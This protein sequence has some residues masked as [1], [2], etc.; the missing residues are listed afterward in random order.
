MPRLWKAHIT[1]ENIIIAGKVRGD[2]VAKRCLFLCR[3]LFCRNIS[4]PKLNIVEGAV[5]HGQCQ[6]MEDMLNIDEV[7]KYLEIDMPAILELADAGKSRPYAA[8]TPGH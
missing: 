6:M 8:A 4:T 7:A 5:F 2:V 1:G 3:R